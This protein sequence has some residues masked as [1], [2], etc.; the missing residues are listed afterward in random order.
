VV[1]TIVHF[2]KRRELWHDD[3]GRNAEQ[4]ALIS[5]CLCVI[6][7]RCRDDAALLLFG[8]ELGKR[9]PCAAFLKTSGPLQVVELTENLHAGDFAQ[10]N[11]MLTGGIINCGSNAITSRFDVFERNH[12][13]SILGQD[14]QSTRSVVAA[15]L[16]E[17]QRRND[18]ARGSGRSDSVYSSPSRTSRT[19]VASCSESNGLGRK[20]I[21][22][23]RRSCG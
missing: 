22:S 3:G 14:R 4:F 6:A 7:G 18:C 10:R 9:L 17:A 19:L 12:A 5:E 11:G 13:I 2:D 8:R 1:L 15:S 20:N 23:S 21:P 16:C